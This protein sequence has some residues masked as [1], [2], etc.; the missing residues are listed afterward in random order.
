MKDLNPEAFR[1]VV[2]RMLEA[3]GRNFWNPSEE[4]LIKLQDMYDE[5]EVNFTDNNTSVINS[6]YLFYVG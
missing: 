1:N 2:K 4:I 5:I 3:K 6:F